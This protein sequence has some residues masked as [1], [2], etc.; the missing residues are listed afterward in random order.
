MKQSY[1]LLLF[2][3]VIYKIYYLILPYRQRAFC[4]DIADFYFSLS[5][6]VALGDL[7]M[8]LLCD[9]LHTNVAEAAPLKMNKLHF[10]FCPVATSLC[11]YVTFRYIHIKKSAMLQQTYIIY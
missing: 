7:L 8:P 10:K 6:Y 9:L 5:S 4:Q 11:L 3:C 2:M 1:N